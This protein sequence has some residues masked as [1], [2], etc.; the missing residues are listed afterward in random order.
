MIVKR[1]TMEERE[2]LVRCSP[3]LIVYRITF[4]RCR[5]QPS[6]VIEEVNTV[7]AFVHGH[8]IVER[9]GDLSGPKWRTPSRGGQKSW[10]TATS[11][12]S[13]PGFMRCAARPVTTI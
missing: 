1:G 8:G 4:R 6:V 11:A 10:H 5:L 12:G 3:T 7:R 13:A 9:C 2:R